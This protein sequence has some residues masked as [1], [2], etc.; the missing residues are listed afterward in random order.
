[1]EKEPSEIEMSNGEGTWFIRITENGIKFNRDKFPDSKPDDFAKAFMEIL[2]NNFS[3]KF[4]KKLE[5]KEW[6]NN[7][8]IGGKDE[9]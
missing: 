4:T 8:T 7:F 6:K 1:M 2:E 5:D 3:V 9:V